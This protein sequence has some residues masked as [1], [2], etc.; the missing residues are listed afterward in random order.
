[1]LVLVLALVLTLVLA[2]H[3]LASHYVDR[4]QATL[5]ELITPLAQTLVLV[6]LLAL[7]LT[8]DQAYQY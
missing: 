2:G 5:V 7:A 4:H 3:R 8:L 1:M 6:A